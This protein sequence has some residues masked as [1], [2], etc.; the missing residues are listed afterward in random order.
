MAVCILLPIIGFVLFLG[1]WVICEVSVKEIYTVDYVYEIGWLVLLIRGMRTTI[2]W[3]LVFVTIRMIL[4]DYS[5]NGNLL[6]INQMGKTCKVKV[7]ICVAFS[8]INIILLSL[9][10]ILLRNDYL[11]ID[12]EELALAAMFKHYLCCLYYFAINDVLTLILVIAVFK[13]VKRSI[14]ETILV[15]K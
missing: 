3:I 12:D 14:S 11:C 7:Y 2:T 4:R 13:S 15:E 5:E 9:R 1:D 8:V 10:W 6:T